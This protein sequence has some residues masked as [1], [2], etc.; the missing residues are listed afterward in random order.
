MPI[1]PVRK[2][3]LPV[4]GP[5]AR[6][7]PATTATPKQML[8]DE[9]MVGTQPF[10]DLTFSGERYDRGDKAGY[11]HANPALARSDIGPPVRAFAQALLA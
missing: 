5:G 4:A 7:L 8:P 2:S 9:L 6:L 11:M 3:V 1:D 10:H